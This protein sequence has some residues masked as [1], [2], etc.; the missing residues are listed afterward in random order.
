MSDNTPTENL[1]ARWSRR[2][3]ESRQKEGVEDPAPEQIDNEILPSPEKPTDTEAEAPKTDAD[4]PDLGSLKSDDSYSDFLSEGVSKTLRSQALK[5]LFHLSH[6]NITDKLDDYDEDYSVFEP[7]GDTVSDHL[8]Q[9]LD[10]DPAN[11]H[12]KLEESEASSVD[13]ESSIESAEESGDEP[14]ESESVPEI[15][16]Q[17]KL[18]VQQ[19]V[20]Q[21]DDQT[22]TRAESNTSNLKQSALTE[23]QQAGHSDHRPQID[24]TDLKNPTKTKT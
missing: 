23:T 18:S 17:D 21:T 11:T 9:W 22:E 19:T 3:L 13:T 16:E 14:E 15:S 20:G 5:Q 2:K 24:P 7:L 12:T 1:A 10:R 8:K 6:F 4:M